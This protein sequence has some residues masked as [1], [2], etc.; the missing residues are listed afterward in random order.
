MHLGFKSLFAF[1]SLSPQRFKYYFY[2]G[3]ISWQYQ[4]YS[5]ILIL[6]L[7]LLCVM[8]L[9]CTSIQA[10]PCLRLSSAADDQRI[11]SYLHTHLFSIVLHRRRRV[12]P[13]RPMYLLKVGS[14]YYVMRFAYA[15]HVHRQNLAILSCLHTE[16]FELD[17][18]MAPRLPPTKSICSNVHSGAAALSASMMLLCCSLASSSF[19]P[20]K[21]SF[22]S[23]D[24]LNS[25][26]YGVQYFLSITIRF[27]K[28]FL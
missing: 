11:V 28:Q 2:L 23:D 18:E 24:R 27:Q 17:T 4:K 7:C 10:L 14:H 1:F 16:P 15:L 9:V 22:L 3:T 13:R 8:P 25:T 20:R 6:V 5:T 26:M 12:S 19:T 21:S